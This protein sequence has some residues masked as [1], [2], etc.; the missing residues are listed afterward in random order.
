MAELITVDEAKAHLRVDGDD[1]N[2][3]IGDIIVDARG[4]IESYTGLILTRRT[5]KEVL[6]RF[7]SRLR[8]WPI[9]TIDA[10]SYVDGDG[11][12]QLLDAALYV[13]QLAARPGAL[14][15]RSWPSLYRGS[16]ITV[17]LTAGFASVAEVKE[18]APNLMRAMLLLIAG[19]YHDREAGGLGADVEKSAKSLCRNLKD[20]R[21]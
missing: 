8:S 17:D 6:P 4:W 11:V 20:W 14:L 1:E 10:V 12:L 16:R 19:F 15:G 2:G 21:V 5:V 3:L 18:F 9:E 7:T 13:P